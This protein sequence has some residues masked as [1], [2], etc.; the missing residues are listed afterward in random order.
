MPTDAADI[1]LDRRGLLRAAAFAHDQAG[2]H[3]LDILLAELLDR[4]CL[5][6]LVALF[7]R[8][9]A[10]GDAAEQ[11]LC[12]TSCRLWRP[13]A[14]Q[15][16]RVAARPTPCAVLDDIA[17]LAGRINAEPEAGHFVIPDRLAL[18]LRF[19]RFDK[20]FRELR[21]APNP[22][23]R[24]VSSKH[25]ASTRTENKA[26]FRIELSERSLGMSI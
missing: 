1:D 11:G 23:L 26:Y 22:R 24:P 12:L 19:D 15:S 9:V 2:L 17:A 14:V 18:D 25:H 7:G 4:H 21:H 13:D 5:T 20:S 10:P 16:D 6:L 3:I 8:I